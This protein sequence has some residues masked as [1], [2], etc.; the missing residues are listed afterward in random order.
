MVNTRRYVL[1]EA[2]TKQAPNRTTTLPIHQMFGPLMAPQETSINL[3]ILKTRKE[4]ILIAAMVSLLDDAIDGYTV[5][6]GERYAG[7]Y[8][9]FTSDGAPSGQGMGSKI[10]H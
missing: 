6:G 4:E 3:H 5:L 7:K 10:I 8:S 1:D 9:S 2:I